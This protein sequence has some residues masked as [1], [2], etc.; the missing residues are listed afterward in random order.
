[1][2]QG[3]LAFLSALAEDERERIHKRAAEGRSAARCRGV[4][5]GRRPKLTEHQ[6]K[7]A[8]A[9]LAKGEPCRAIAADLAVHHST[10]A[11]LRLPAPTASRELM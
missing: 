3:F 6:Q 7:A 11:R 9:R 1:M 8:L 2:G 5:M 10:I 4:R